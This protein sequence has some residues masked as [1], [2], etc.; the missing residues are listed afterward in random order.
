[1]KIK[2]YYDGQSIDSI[3]DSMQQALE[4]KVELQLIEALSPFNDELSD[5][6]YTIHILFEKDYESLIILLDGLSDE[7]TKIIENSI[8]VVFSE[9]AVLAEYIPTY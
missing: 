3:T 2:I 8:T 1:M 7:L 6:N 5:K 4:E 9:S